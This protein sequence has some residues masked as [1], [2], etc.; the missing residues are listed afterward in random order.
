M[1]PKTK[2]SQATNGKAEL[3]LQ[4]NVAQRKEIVRNMQQLFND[5]PI[6]KKIGATAHALM[7]ESIRFQFEQ[8]PVAVK[9]VVK[10]LDAVG[11]DDEPETQD[12]HRFSFEWQHP[13]I[14]DYSITIEWDMS[15][16][17][18]ESMT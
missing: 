9:K 5:L 13:C 11:A 17:H 3:K 1:M 7:K 15:V 6:S 2:L 12:F 8:L 18:F 10:E 14:K 4:A 16:E